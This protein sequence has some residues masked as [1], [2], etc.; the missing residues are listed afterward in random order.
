MLKNVAPPSFRKKTKPLYKDSLLGTVIG[1]SGLISLGVFIIAICYY[2][3]MLEPNPETTMFDCGGHSCLDLYYK[4][5]GCR[6]PDVYN[7]AFQLKQPSWANGDAKYASPGEVGIPDTSASPLNRRFLEASEG[8]NQDGGDS[9]NQDGGDSSNQDGGDSS[10]NQNGGDSSNQNGGDSSSNQNGGDSNQNG[11]DSSSNQGASPC[12]PKDGASYFIIAGQHSGAPN[13]LEN[14]LVRLKYARTDPFSV[15]NLSWTT[16]TLAW[17][18]SMTGF[19]LVLPYLGDKYMNPE[20]ITPG[21]PT[22][23]E[24]VDKDD[25]STLTPTE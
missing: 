5:S 13:A 19:S 21:A 1:L 14:I 10:S 17:T 9:S 25:V 22:E 15:L 23:V 7:G 18:F 11:G 3:F 4:L 2:A 8:E 16:A 12:E 20:A 24:I 6:F